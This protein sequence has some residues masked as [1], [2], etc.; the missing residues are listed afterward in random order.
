LAGTHAPYLRTDIENLVDVTTSR[1][2]TEFFI[3][4]T[5]LLYMLKDVIKPETPWTLGELPEG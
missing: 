5:E 4:H 1:V 2:N 3:D